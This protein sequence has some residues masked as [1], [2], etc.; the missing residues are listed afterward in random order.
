MDCVDKKRIE[1]AFYN[2]K[3]KPKTWMGFA[4]P[5]LLSEGIIC[6]T[7]LHKRGEANDLCRCDSET[8]QWTEDVPDSACQGIGCQLYFRKPMGKRK[9]TS[10]K[11][12]ASRDPQ[13][14]WRASFGILL[15]RGWPP[16]VKEMTLRYRHCAGAECQVRWKAEHVSELPQCYHQIS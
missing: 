12:D 15:W 6:Y 13:I 4:I 11:N 8:A 10:D 9:V 3:S 7:V 5:G 1:S 16:I 2:P 14:L